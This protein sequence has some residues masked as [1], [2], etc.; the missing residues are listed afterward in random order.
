MFYAVIGCHCVVITSL[1]CHCVSCH[2]VF[3][4]SLRQCG[5]SVALGCHCVIALS[6][7]HS[8][9]IVLV[10]CQYV[11]LSLLCHCASV[12]FCD[13]V[14]HCGIAL[15]LDCVCVCVCELYAGVNVLY[16]SWRVHTQWVFYAVIG[17][18]VLG[19]SDILSSEWC[20]PFML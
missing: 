17:V 15:S 10:R 11:I 6:L 12:S 16:T 7:R 2:S 13:C 5:V 4:A 14:C 3:I 9:V 18:W 19:P 20:A 8:V 1:C